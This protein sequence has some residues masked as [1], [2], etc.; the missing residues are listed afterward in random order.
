[1]RVLIVED[2]GVTRRIIRRELEPGG[3]ELFDA[4][5]GEQ[6]L[7]L[8]RRHKPHLITLDVDMPHLDGYQT[9]AQ[10]RTLRFE[11]E[12]EPGTQRRVPVV[13]VTS[14]ES[15]ECRAKGF[16]AG[17]T[18]FFLKPFK[19]GALLDVVKR[20]LR[21]PS[22]LDGAT[23][24]VVEDSSVIRHA[25]ADM[26]KR[27]GLT[28]LEASNGEQGFHCARHHAHQL[29]LIVTDYLMPGI[30]GE[31]LCAKI[32]G[33]LGLTDIPII[34]L[35]GVKD[36]ATIVEMFEAGASDFIIKPF[37]I[38]ELLARI[39][40]HL[41]VSL[42]NRELGQRNAAM[43]EELE[44]AGEAQRA[45][46]HN[47]VEVEFLK[48]SVLFFPFGEVSGDTYDF[49]VNSEGNFC[50]FLGDAT[51]HGVAAALMTMMVQSGLD[52]IGRDASTEEVLTTLDR[53]I[54]ERSGQRFVTGIYLTVSPTGLL[55]F[56]NAGHPPL[57]HLPATGDPKV[58]SE[59]GGTPL[60]LMP[61]MIPFGHEQI[62]LGAGDRFFVYTDGL[63][64]WEN[65][66]HEQFGVGG[67]LDFLKQNRGAPVQSLV[68]DALG[69]LRAFARGTDCND[70]FT[71]IGFEYRGGA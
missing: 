4:A 18:D 62:Q 15:A 39:N 45:S 42:L 12:E 24:L 10:L 25:V 33:E 61:G 7:D 66:G 37:S 49:A 9:C 60:G 48:T 20:I 55:A 50:A 52:G 46:M 22:V 34:F 13:F 40:V 6:A 8:A 1:M 11:S 2:S 47:R 30:N 14:D 57:I 29:D 44:L 16:E 21:P 38:E 3:F 51:G 71:L 31:Q 19:Q 64:E 17:A 26:L 59:T 23:A 58:F 70:D 69:A 35:S 68:A 28:V 5:D 36:S 56:S 63:T 53:S 32:R 65:P 43:L 41:K 27:H 67:L 54:G